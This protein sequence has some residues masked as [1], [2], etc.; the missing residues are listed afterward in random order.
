MLNQKRLSECDIHVGGWYWYGRLFE[1][2]GCSKDLFVYPGLLAYYSKSIILRRLLPVDWTRVAKN[3][4][5][6][7]LVLTAMK[8]R[9]TLLIS[10]LTQLLFF[11]SADVENDLRYNGNANATYL[12]RGGAIW[13]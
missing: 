2:I 12:L 8:N 6:I 11:K 1:V 9:H 3:N 13:P 10:V 7:T 4:N 5:H